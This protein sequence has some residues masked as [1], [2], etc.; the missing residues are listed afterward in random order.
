MSSAS[1]VSLLSCIERMN[2]SAQTRLCV[3]LD[4][5]LSRATSLAQQAGIN[6]SKVS[7]VYVKQW[8]CEEILAAACEQGIKCLKVQ[9]AYFESQGAQGFELMESLIRRAHEQGFWVIL[10]GKRGDISSTMHSYGVMAFEKLQADALTINPYMGADVWKALSPWLKA[11]KYAFVLWWTSQI[12]GSEV[13]RHRSDQ[14]LDLVSFM[15]A[16]LHKSAADEGIDHALGLVL[17]ATQI[18]HLSP[19]HK[20][21]IR[22][23]SLLIPG[24][25]AQGGGMVGGF[26]SKRYGDLWPISRGLLAPREGVVSAGSFS[27]M[28][29]ENI[30]YFKEQLLVV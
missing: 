27:Q 23:R 13:Q 1:S 25:G 4:P 5:E 29:R 6:T 8:L 19:C 17:G 28:L 24:V 12:S 22:E 7:A 2:K 10:D 15:P 21:H 18:P 14:G 20:N 26:F 3:G 11:G 9:M 30:S 16:Y